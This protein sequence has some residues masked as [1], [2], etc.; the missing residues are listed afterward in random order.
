MRLDILKALNDARRER[1]AGVM[2]TRLADGDQRFVE[3]SAV[4]A[5]P[6]AESLE[7]ALRMGKSGTVS[8]NGGSVASFGKMP[9]ARRN[10]K[11]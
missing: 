1:R 4:G 2:V 10:N 3:G 6:L 5:D 11:N 7:S 9:S 8:F